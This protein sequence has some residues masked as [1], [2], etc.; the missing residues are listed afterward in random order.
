MVKR[1]R[2]AVA[3]GKAVFPAGESPV[4]PIARFRYVAIP[5]FVTGNFTSIAWCKRPGC[6]VSEF[7]FTT[8]G[9]TW[10]PSKYRSLNI[11]E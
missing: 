8:V 1:T 5:Q 6:L 10:G 11:K 7:F 4:I 3:A 2:G 9:A